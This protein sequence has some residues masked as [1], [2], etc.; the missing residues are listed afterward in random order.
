MKKIK[1]FRKRSRGHTLAEL[2]VALAIVV[3]VS[4]ALF[5]FSMSSQREI[6]LLTSR[7]GSIKKVRLAM[8]QMK[9]DIAGACG[10]T[11]ICPDYPTAQFT[12]ND[13]TMVLYLLPLDVNR[14]PIT[15]GTD[16][17]YIIYY[18]AD[19]NPP[20]PDLMD[21]TKV[22][23]MRRVVPNATVSSFR[24]TAAGEVVADLTVKD[25]EVS[26][27]LLLVTEWDMDGDGDIEDIYFFNGSGLASIANLN[28]VE[29][30]QF[31]IASQY[32]VKW[33]NPGEEKR[34]P[35]VAGTQVWFRNYP[36]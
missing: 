23:L 8:E 9:K 5:S 1:I 29:Y 24:N 16:Y 18:L 13:Y 6:A 36:Y 2:M 32:G 12:T 17:D 33:Q 11:T 3:L 35:V 14:E 7:S 34:D 30:I 4:I 10:V 22:V 19:V 20:D 25:D 28:D 31:R 21:D 15:G 26:L 27:G